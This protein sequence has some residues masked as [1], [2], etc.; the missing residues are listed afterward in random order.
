MSNKR[1]KYF[2]IGRETGNGEIFA[3]L[4]EVNSDLEDDTD[5]LMNDSNTEFVLE[6]RSEIELGPDDEPL[7]LPVP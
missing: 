2:K 1:K 5:N 3:L 4:N 6:E 7:N